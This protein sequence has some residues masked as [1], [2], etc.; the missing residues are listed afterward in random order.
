VAFV[1]CVAGSFDCARVA[2]G[3]V[4]Q[5]LAW[6]MARMAFLVGRFRSIA[7]E[8]MDSEGRKFGVGWERKDLNCVSEHKRSVKRKRIRR[9]Q[10]LLRDR[11]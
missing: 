6:P 1:L 7:E 8:W 3:G 10:S 4:V 9:C 5:A 2:V 11:G